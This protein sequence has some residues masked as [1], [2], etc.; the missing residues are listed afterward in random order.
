MDIFAG[1]CLGGFLVKDDLAMPA[2]R[3]FSG[4][5]LMSPVTI[6]HFSATGLESASLAKALTSFREGG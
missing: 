1:G 6:A 2:P 3:D 5:Y 4:D